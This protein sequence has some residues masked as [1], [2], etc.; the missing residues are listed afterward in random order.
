M[1][2]FLAYHG[3]TDDE[4]RA[5]W[6]SRY[7][8][9]KEVRA[10][11]HLANSLANKILEEEITDIAIVVPD[12][13]FWFGKAMEQ[14]F[15][16]SIW[17]GGFAN[18]VA[19]KAGMWEYQKPNYAKR[20]NRL[21]IDLTA[22][23]GLDMR[24]CDLFSVPPPYKAASEISKD[25]LAIELGRLFTTFYGNTYVVGTRLITRALVREGYTWAD[26]DIN[27]L[28]N[29]A[30]K[31]FQRN[32]YLRQPYVELGKGLLEEKLGDL[33]KRGPAAIQAELMKIQDEA[34]QGKLISN[35]KGLGLPDTVTEMQALAQTISNLIKFADKEGRKFVPFIY[36]EGEKYYELRDHLMA[37]GIEWVMQGTGDQHISYQQVLAQPQKYL[38]FIISFVPERLTRGRPAIGFSKGYLNNVSPNMVRDLF[39]QASYKALTEPRKDESG[40]DVKGALGVFLR[41]QDSREVRDMLAGSFEEAVRISPRPQAV[42]TDAAGKGLASGRSAEENPLEGVTR[43]QYIYNTYVRDDEA[44][45]RNTLVGLGIDT[46]RMNKKVLILYDT[47]ID[48]DLDTAHVARAGEVAV[49][50]YMNGAVTE[51]RGTGK[52]LLDAARVQARALATTDAIVTI[53]GDATLKEVGQD[54]LKDL[55]KVINVQNPDNRHI[56]VIGLYDLALKIAYDLGDERILEC[57]NRIAIK[58]PNDLTPFTTEDI[59]RGVIR[60]LPKIRPVDMA[61]AVEAYKAAQAALSS[62]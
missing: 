6:Q 13:L 29:P 44:A 18:L 55:G 28:E 17:Q 38:P 33:Q 46:E 16:E 45:L 8:G 62:L 30:T 41:M 24:G 26:V 19:V 31:I 61:E 25:K 23:A 47:G 58:D 59:R 3:M 1:M 27:D 60:I 5:Y 54:G 56:P 48:P 7:E 2:T 43:D 14:N 15:N 4:I 37:L 50:K 35:V 36:L 10:G 53:A 32:L 42:G 21:V 39:A 57:L 49:N 11:T 52:A 51:V 40:K 9:I 12:E 20:P 22:G 34:R